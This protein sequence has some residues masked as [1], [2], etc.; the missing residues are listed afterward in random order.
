MGIAFTANAIILNFEV[1]IYSLLCKITKRFRKIGKK[2]YDF[3]EIG[4]DL[5]LFGEFEG[6][7]LQ[8]VC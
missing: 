3:I 4:E 6:W 1:D 7:K 2:I 8:N 5:T